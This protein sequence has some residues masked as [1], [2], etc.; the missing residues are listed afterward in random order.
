MILSKFSRRERTLVIATLGVTVATILYG[1]VIEPVIRANTRL[2]DLIEAKSLKLK[3]GYRLL[4]R[5]D[6]I[7][8]E[9]G[10]YA[11]M[12]KPTSSNEEEIASMLKVIEEIAR[13]D[14]IYITNIR[15]QPVRDRGLYSNRPMSRFSLF[16]ALGSTSP[17]PS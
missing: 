14:S 12:L 9:Y 1:F 5:E 4:G 2:N 3:K 17:M 16:T 7:Q 13:G 6:E 11:N 15:P 10:L 8:A